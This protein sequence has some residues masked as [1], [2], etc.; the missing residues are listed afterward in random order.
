MANSEADAKAQAGLS[1]YKG[2]MLNHIETVYRPGERHLAVKLFKAIGCEVSEFGE[3][4]RIQIAPGE[5]D[6]L[7]NVLYASEVTPEQWQFEQR[8]QAAL[9]GESPL[10]VAHDGYD[11]RFRRQPQRTAHFGI[12]FPS[13]AKLEAALSDLENNLDPELK[14]RLEVAAVFRPGDPGSY[15]KIMQAFL[16]TDIVAAGIVT[17]GQ[18]IELQ[19]QPLED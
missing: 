14:G 5:K 4:L 15:G 17:L 10:A 18:H 3:Y 9:A 13:Y 7:N 6:P 12:R 1:G 16:K 2:R 11:G 8:L 19:A